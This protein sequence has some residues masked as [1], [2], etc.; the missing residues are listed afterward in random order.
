MKRPRNLRRGLV[1]AGTFGALVLA[2]SSIALAANSSGKPG[3]V[4]DRERVRHFVPENLRG[5]PELSAV[6]FDSTGKTF[7]E[8]QFDRGVIMHV[9]A[10]APRSRCSSGRTSRCGGP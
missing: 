4:R 9:D 5:A 6:V 8:L 3:G 10:T 2:V 1:V 7:V